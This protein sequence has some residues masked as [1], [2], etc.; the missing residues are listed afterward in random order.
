[1]EF[2]AGNVALITTKEAWDQKLE[3]ARKDGKIVSFT[4]T[5]FLICSTI[6][7]KAYFHFVM[8]FG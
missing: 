1:V 7:L 8:L 4:L 2:A 6:K 3:E 5:Y